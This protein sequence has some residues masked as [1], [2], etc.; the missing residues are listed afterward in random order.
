M[1]NKYVIDELVLQQSKTVLRLLPYH[2]ELNP[3]ELAWS[4][5]KQYVR[6]N[7]KTFKLPDVKK[8]LVEGVDEV[9]SQMWKNFISHIVKEENKFWT[10]DD[11]VDELTAEQHPVVMTI[12]QS[13]SEDDDDFDI[14]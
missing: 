6:S 7:N 12:G 11:I 1:Y 5:V 10:M 8:L 2:C 13:D 14:L 4:V 9:D 3:I